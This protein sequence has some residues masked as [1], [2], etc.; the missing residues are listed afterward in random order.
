MNRPS[1]ALDKITNTFTADRTFFDAMMAQPSGEAFL[2]MCVW[3]IWLQEYL[4]DIQQSLHDGLKAHGSEYQIWVVS[5]I[6]GTAQSI[7]M[8]MYLLS[9]GVAHE[10][11]ASARRALEYLGMACHLVRDPDKARFL[12]EGEESK[13]FKTA[14]I[15]G[16]PREVKRL[17]PEGI[18]YRF[19]GMTTGMG[20]TATELYRIFSRFN[21]H[22]G[23]MCSLVG[24][25]PKPTANSC[26]F[27]NR[28]MEEITENMPLFK[29]IP[30][31]TAIELMD[32]VGHY[33]AHNQRIK[34]AGASVLVWLDHEN[35]H[36]LE[37][38]EAVRRQFGLSGGQALPS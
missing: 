25:S 16:H 5:M 34:Q 6:G 30:E 29:T 18:R 36:W 26:A 37:R 12:G 22:G 35:R 33:G 31:I 14:F 2:G 8:L 7:G 15:Q 13:E 20:K 23:T 19:A 24:L 3:Y 11:A 10:A 32:L 28:S 17:K 4:H 21:V 9:R 38:V 27:H 1:D